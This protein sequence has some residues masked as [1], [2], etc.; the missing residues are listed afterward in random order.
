M[1]NIEAALIEYFEQGGYQEYLNDTIKGILSKQPM[2]KVVKNT[3]YGRFD[4]SDFALESLG[5][6]W[7]DPRWMN[8]TDDRLIALI[9]K[10]G[11]KKVSGLA[12]SLE[13]VEV[14]FNSD[15]SII[16]DD[17]IEDLRW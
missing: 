9:E 17:G 15:W 12:S 8:R 7:D 4:L 16:D 1:A 14:P 3:C 5:L 6:K 13:I 2:I 10:E 11:S